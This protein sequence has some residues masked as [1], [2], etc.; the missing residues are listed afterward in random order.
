MECR[1]NLTT[2]I[3]N[4]TI[5][6]TQCSYN[7]DWLPVLDSMIFIFAFNLGFGSMIWTTVV[8]ILPP[9]IRSWTNGYDLNYE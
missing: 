5:I 8:E 3:T 2:S 1:D 4:D 6:A 7:I 9:T